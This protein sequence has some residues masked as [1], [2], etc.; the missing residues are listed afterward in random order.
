[1]AEMMKAVVISI[2]GIMKTIS[3]LQKITILF[4]LVFS[5][6]QWAVFWKSSPAVE[7]SKGPV[8][9]GKQLPLLVFIFISHWPR[10]FLFCNVPCGWNSCIFLISNSG[11]FFSSGK[12]KRKITNVEFQGRFTPYG[13]FAQCS[14][15]T[16]CVLLTFVN[17]KT[18]IVLFIC[19]F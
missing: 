18:F 14:L 13:N 3:E 6:M 2:C 19:I 15:F 12:K 5:P 7:I 16:H 4:V 17:I 10:S 11:H 9:L 8:M 1:M